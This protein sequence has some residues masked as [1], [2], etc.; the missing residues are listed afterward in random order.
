MLPEIVKDIEE[1]S[2]ISFDGEFTGLASERN[3]M[4]FDTSQ[5]YYEK[6]LRTSSGFILVQFGLTFFKV[7]KDPENEELEK[8]S[9]K[10]YNIY[11]YPQSKFA[12]F[13]CQGQSLSFLAANGF[14]FNKLFTNGISYCNA[15]EEEKVR[16]EVKDKQ[17]VRSEQL[18]QRI[19]SEE[20]DITNRNFIPVPENEIGLMESAREKI[21]RVADGSV[22][23]TM[24]DK[25]NAFQRKLIYELIEREFNNKV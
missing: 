8:V 4:P 14:D 24:F 18:Q 17:T 13:L 9:L 16:Q 12:T 7:K 10:S 15:A 3:V 25:L 19:S 20:Q 22:K 21:Q 23:E 11:V 5:E 1:S 2:F 6:R